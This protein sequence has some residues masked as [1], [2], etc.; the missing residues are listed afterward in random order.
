VER[1]G[2]GG[3]TRLRTQASNQENQATAAALCCVL[4]AHRMRM[5]GYKFVALPGETDAER[6][7]RLSGR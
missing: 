7:N 4:T 5:Y 6:P 3:P 1:K 2:L